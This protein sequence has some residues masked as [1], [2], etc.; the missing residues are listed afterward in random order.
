MTT[1]VAVELPELEHPLQTFIRNDVNDLNRLE[2]E[3]F[4]SPLQKNF[5]TI[6][7]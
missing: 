5:E 1:N 7:S 2:V 6:H 3:Q 4:Y